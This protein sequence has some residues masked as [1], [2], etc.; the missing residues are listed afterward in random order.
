MLDL[1]EYQQILAHLHA[2]AVADHLCE[3]RWQQLMLALYRCGRRSEALAAYSRARAARSRSSAPT[4]DGNCRLCSARSSRAPLPEALAGM[5]PA[6]PPR[7]RPLY[8]RPFAARAGT[9]G[10]PRVTGCQAA[11]AVC[12]CRR[13][14]ADAGR[15]ARDPASSLQIE[16]GEIDLSHWPL[17]ACAMVNPD[18][19]GSGCGLVVVAQFRQQRER[20][21]F[22]GRGFSA[23]PGACCPC[24]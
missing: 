16:I 13:P 24:I 4:R 2:R 1:G 14:G 5:A 3:R 6:A 19:W 23:A 22:Q 15:Q 10:A 18:R 11:L 20:V 8:S 9:G 12:P 7:W 17:L 21:P